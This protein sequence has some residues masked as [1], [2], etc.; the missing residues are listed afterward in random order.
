MIPGISDASIWRGLIEGGSSAILLGMILMFIVPRLIALFKDQTKAFRDEMAKEREA[1][2]E[3]TAKITDA[4][5]TLTNS[6]HE[7]TTELRVH[8]RR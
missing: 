4:L 7:H 6:I 1:H 3:E 8:S 5:V 2:R